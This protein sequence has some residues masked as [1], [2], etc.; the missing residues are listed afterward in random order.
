MFFFKPATAIAQ[1][2]MPWYSDWIKKVKV[3]FCLLYSIAIYHNISHCNPCIL[4]CIANILFQY[5]AVNEESLNCACWPLKRS[6][7]PHRCFQRGQHT[8]RW[9]VVL[10]LSV[11]PVIFKLWSVKMSAGAT[12]LL[13]FNKQKNTE[14]FWSSSLHQCVWGGLSFDI[15]PLSA[16]LSL[17]WLMSSSWDMLQFISCSF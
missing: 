3:S 17:L 8:C 4:M 6:V 15:E 2:V 13:H 10:M 7:H 16:T 12:Y 14:R 5:T 9:R 11:T 1:K